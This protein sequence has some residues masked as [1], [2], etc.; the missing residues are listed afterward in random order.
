MSKPLAWSAPVVLADP[1]PGDFCCMPVP[2]YFGTVIKA[3]QYLAQKVEGLPA[4]YQDYD[5]AEVYVGMPDKAGPHGYTYSAYPD[6]NQ[7]GHSGKHALPCP[8]EQLAGSIWSSGIIE[9]TPLQRAGIIG[10]CTAH[11]DSFYSWPDYGAIALHALRVPAPGLRTYIKSTKQLICS[12]YTDS[13]F[14]Q[15]AN[16]HLF[17]DGRW[18]GY[19]TPGDL[20]L[21]LE[22]KAGLH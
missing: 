22:T 11:P 16:V 5:H 13:A 1:Q 12:Y 7:A 4:R 6:N 20:A 8:P 21:M 18:E 15:G 17:D 9:L 14:S 2:G 10:W 19:V 3:G